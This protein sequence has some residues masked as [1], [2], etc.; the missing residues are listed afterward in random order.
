MNCD[1][2]GETRT[3]IVGGRS[4]Y[5]HIRVLLDGFLLKLI[6]KQLISI[7]QVEHEYI[8]MLPPPPPINAVVSPRNANLNLKSNLKSTL[9]RQQTFF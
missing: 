8:N 4:V 1:Y 2:R 9:T 5:S 6:Q 7:F 3:L